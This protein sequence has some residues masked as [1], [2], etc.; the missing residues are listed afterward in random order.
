MLE[1]LEQILIWIF[2]LLAYVKRVK[3]N[4]S[5]HSDFGG[6]YSQATAAQSKVREEKWRHADQYPPFQVFTPE[7]LRFCSTSSTYFNLSDKIFTTWSRSQCLK[8][9]KKC[10]IWIFTR[11]TGYLT[12]KINIYQMFEFSRQKWSESLAIWEN[13]AFW[14]IFKDSFDRYID[15]SFWVSI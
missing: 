2:Q 6:H 11:C 3:R 8:I 12:W 15:G 7:I 10:L 13:G 4:L 1:T 5:L 9:T 14:G